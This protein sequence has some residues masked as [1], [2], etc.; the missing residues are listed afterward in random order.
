MTIVTIN[1]YA[2][3]F[4]G[5]S[6]IE[7]GMCHNSIHSNLIVTGEE[8]MSLVVLEVGVRLR[9]GDAGYVKTKVT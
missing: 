8:N 4:I 9:Q 5:Q 7:L 3:Q 6:E 1:F 2:I